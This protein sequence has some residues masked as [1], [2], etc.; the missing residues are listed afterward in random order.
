MKLLMSI[1]IIMQSE[2]CSERAIDVKNSACNSIERS[3]VP[4]RPDLEKIGAPGDEARSSAHGIEQQVLY[5]CV[6]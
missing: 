2:N 5:I 4:R 1:T 6:T 3:L